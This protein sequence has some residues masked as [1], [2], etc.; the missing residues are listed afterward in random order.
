MRI[1]RRLLNLPESTRRRSARMSALAGSLQNDDDNET[2][3]VAAVC[4]RIGALPSGFRAARRLQNE[5]TTGEWTVGDLTV[6]PTENLYDA[7]VESTGSTRL[8]RAHSPADNSSGITIPRLLITVLRLVATCG[9]ITN[10]IPRGRLHVASTIGPSASIQYLCV[11]DSHI[12]LGLNLPDGHGHMTIRNARW[13]YCSAGRKDEVHEWEAIPALPFSQLRHSSIMRRS[14]HAGEA[15]PD[16]QD[17][18]RS[19]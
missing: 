9:K 12:H 14:G 4:E 10:E 2:T 1:D 5:R 18:D 13:A 17:E 15:R 11:S 8:A 3:A 6:M 19:G 16:E 7:C